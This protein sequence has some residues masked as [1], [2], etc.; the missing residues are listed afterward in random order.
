MWQICNRPVRVTGQKTR[1]PCARRDEGNAYVQLRHLGDAGEALALAWASMGVEL[2]ELLSVAQ[3]LAQ[4]LPVRS[5]TVSVLEREIESVA[6]R[7]GVLGQGA[8]WSLR[9]SQ[10]L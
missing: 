3:A 8:V 6:Q 1:H 7:E 2:D 10:R 5:L 4:S 9:L